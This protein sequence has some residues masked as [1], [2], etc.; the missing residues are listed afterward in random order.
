[1]RSMCLALALLGSSCIVE[2]PTK[3]GAAAAAPKA[4]P[5]PP[6]EV[7]VGA[8]FGD[9][10]ELTNAVLNPGRG[11]AG[12]GVRVL[13]NFRVLATPDR[14]YAIF[15]HMEDV[16][17]RAERFNVDH[18]PRKPTTQWKPDEVVQDIFD[19]MIPPGHNVRGLSLAMGFWDPRTNARLPIVNK[20][21][22]PTDGRDRLYVA[23]FPVVQPQ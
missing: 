20:D 7:K 21:A 5:S 12:E 17:G 10:I 14:D 2:A 16:D 23:R 6:A 13:L 9:Y 19:I 22:V 15:V 1:M 8:Q 11:V 4:P 3:E 18:S